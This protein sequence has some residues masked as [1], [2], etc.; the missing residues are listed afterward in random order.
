MVGLFS[1][2]YTT[3]T[4]PISWLSNSVQ[5]K[6][7]SA[8]TNEKE[9]SLE[10]NAMSISASE[11]TKEN[12]EKKSASH[13]DILSGYE[14][15]TPWD[16]PQEPLPAQEPRDTDYDVNF[17]ASKL[18]SGAYYGMDPFQEEAKDNRWGVSSIVHNPAPV[19]DGLLR[20]EPNVTTKLF[21]SEFESN[22]FGG[23]DVFNNHFSDTPIHTR[24]GSTPFNHFQEAKGIE[25]AD[26]E[27]E[28]DSPRSEILQNT[29]SFELDQEKEAPQ[30]PVELD[31]GPEQDVEIEFDT[32]YNQWPE[33]I[34][35]VL[36][37]AGL[38]LGA[39]AARAKLVEFNP[40]TEMLSKTKT[41]SHVQQDQPDPY[42][43]S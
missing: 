10:T 12:L 35:Y 42:Y 24:F 22:P 25:E 8:P 4:T 40:L 32:Q 20:F 15:L 21:T 2:S 29:T 41:D 14:Q 34:G 38:A 33:A 7:G 37:G 28:P 5:A 17:K 23:N 6:V 18:S 36:G 13:D 27:Q 39:L 9:Q 1:I 16:T 31:W 30:T 11:S 43:E 3:L 19:D 26:E